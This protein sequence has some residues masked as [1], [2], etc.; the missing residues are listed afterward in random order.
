MLGQLRDAPELLPILALRRYRMI[1]LVRDNLFE[2]VVSRLA[3]EMTGDA[4]SRSEVPKERQIEI[5]PAAMV[6][7]MRRRRLGLRLVR[8]LQAGWPAPSVVVRYEYLR[9]S[10]CAALGAI[11][12]KLGSSSAPHEVTSPLKRRVQK[13]YRE[14]IINYDE[15]CEAAR[16]AGFA[17]ALPK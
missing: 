12:A 3:L 5:D 11:L 13:P 9:T 15:V 16:S 7:Q 17:D 2:G 10:Q 6:A 1:A 8:T 14:F 4:Q